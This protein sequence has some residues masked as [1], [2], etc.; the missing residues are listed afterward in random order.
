MIRFTLANTVWIAAPV[1]LWLAG[2]AGNNVVAPVAGEAP[3]ARLA[4]I[5]IKNS[6]TTIHQI[7]KNNTLYSITF[8]HNLN[9]HK[10]TQ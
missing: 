6:T 5:I 10:I 9:Y 8:Q 2:C 7:I 4:A 3:P 1:V